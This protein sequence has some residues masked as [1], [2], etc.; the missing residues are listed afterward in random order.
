MR[1]G[2]RG[3]I[4]ERGAAA[5]PRGE[6]DGD[7]R[8]PD[9][10]VAVQQC[11]LAAREER[12]PQPADALGSGTRATELAEHRTEGRHEASPLSFQPICCLPRI[13]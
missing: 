7:E 8:L 9:A 1:A 4:W 5:Q 6:V 2:G 11:E 3:A 10:G 12:F 13:P